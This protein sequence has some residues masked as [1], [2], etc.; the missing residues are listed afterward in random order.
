MKQKRK[1]LWVA[2]VALVGILQISNGKKVDASSFTNLN[3]DEIV[4]E[5]GAG[6]NLGNQLEASTDEDGQGETLWGNPTITKSALDHVKAAGFNTVRIPV[7]WLDMIG[8]APNYTINQAWLNRVQ[9]VVDYAIA[10]DMYVLIDVHNDG[11]ISVNGS[12]ILTNASDQNTIKTKFAKVWQQIA[13]RFKDYDEHLIFE[14]MNEVGAESSSSETEIREAISTIMEYNQTFVNTVRQTGGN[15]NKRWLMVPGWNTNVDYTAG[16]YGFQMPSD[17]NLASTVPSGQKRIMVS[18]HYYTPW[19]FCGEE[20]GVITTWGSDKQN[21]IVWANESFLKEE[22]E[23]MYNGFVNSGYP[24]VIGEY[25]CVDKSNL[26]SENLESRIYYTATLCKYAKMYGCVPVYWDNGNN[27]QYGLAIFNRW[28]NFEITQPG[29]LSAIMH[30]YG[31]ETSTDVSLNKSNISMELGDT[32]VSINA[33]L[34]P[35]SAADWIEWTSSNP[36]VAT[37]NRYGQVKA[38]GIG[39]ATITADIHGSSA[40]CQVTVTAPNACR[41]KLYM[42]NSSTWQTTE[43]EGYVSVSADGTYT[44]SIT[45]TRAEM[46]NITLLYLQDLATNLG[47]IDTSI[48][49]GANITLNS[50]KLNGQSCTLKNTTSQYTTTQ[51]SG[52]FINLINV[53][54]GSSISNLTS[55]GGDGCYFSGLTY[56]DTNTIQVS[57]SLSNTVFSNS[58]TSSE[59]VVYNGSTGFYESTSPDWLMNASNS[60]LITITYHCTDSSHAGWGVLGWGGMVDGNW[61]NGPGY[62]ADSSNALSE[63]VVTVTAGALK[64]ALGISSGSTVSYLSL[65]NYNGGVLD[66]I[67]ISN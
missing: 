13:T 23:K 24:V 58:S 62:S 33:A 22:M 5:M 39:T 52:L 66:K 38:T 6:W 47:A 28:N 20:D 43:S 55:T 17:N 59:S 30:Y 44:I 9:E 56:Q 7:S 45:G 48:I 40:T 49:T 42:Q 63:K 29:I 53:W 64:S 27:G 25:G 37:V 51:G 11:S 41:I 57:F 61:V 31:A 2:I 3:Q 54:G 26:D 36:A 60:D 65:S 10:N 1:Y 50:V 34:S 32:A 19:E 46:S 12:W 4:S 16:D 14:S 18:V 15:N 67:T 21:T 35:S 8:S